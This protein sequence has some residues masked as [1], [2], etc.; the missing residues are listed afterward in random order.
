MK[1]RGE[2]MREKK[3]SGKAES[4]LCPILLHQS[5]SVQVLTEAYIQLRT[6]EITKMYEVPQIHKG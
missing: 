1:E 3:K 6:R 4:F 5:C 2:K